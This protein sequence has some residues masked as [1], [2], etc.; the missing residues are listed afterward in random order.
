MPS[1]IRSSLR[2]FSLAV[3]FL[4]LLTA[5]GADTGSTGSTSTPT[6]V[7]TTAP[8]PTPT[9]AP[10]DT[11]TTAPTGG[12]NS[13]SIASFAFS[14][15]SLTVAVGT[16]VTWTNNDSVTH[17]VTENNG[18]FDSKDL[19]PGQTFSFTFDKAGTYSYHCN[20]HPSMTATIVAQ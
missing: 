14:P 12:G 19:A 17:T 4:V 5:C 13:V 6:T 20:I 7:A 1:M 10:A 11:P 16:K 3:I 18:A 9:T 2:F 15:A 8:A